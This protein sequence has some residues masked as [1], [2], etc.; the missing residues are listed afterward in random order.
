MFEIGWSEILVIVIVMI[1]VVGPK[2]LPKMLRAFGKAT[3]KFRATAGEFRKQFDEA[4]KEAELDDV[5]DIVNEAKSLDP[6]SD[7]R[8]VFDPVRTIGEEIRSSLKDATVTG[9]DNVAV[10][11]PAAPDATQLQPQV[12][13]PLAAPDVAKKPARVKSKTAGQ[14]SGAAATVSAPVKKPEPAKAP[15]AGAKPKN[16]PAADIASSAT[17]R[18][19]TKRTAKPKAEARDAGTKS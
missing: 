14:T 11:D 10:P 4:L 2:D 12:M 3:S 18:T 8:K 13:E 7:I 5:R 6:R 9:K 15:K 17:A 16:G 19:A 1:V